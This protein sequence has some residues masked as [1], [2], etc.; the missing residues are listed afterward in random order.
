MN[1]LDQLAEAN[2]QKAI[3]AGAL[4]GLAGSG[5]PLEL[6][7]DSMVPE[8]LRAAY[9]VLRNSGYLPQEVAIYSEIRN[10]ES[11]IGRMEQGR[12][13]ASAVK[14]LSLL[15]ARLGHERCLDLSGRGDY[16]QAVV[17]KL[18]RR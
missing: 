4:D 2:I 16:Y 6:D 3:D 18:G 1:L 17:D 14:R 10:V 12:E 5:R 11:L 9:R 7:D 8:N 15:R 13:R